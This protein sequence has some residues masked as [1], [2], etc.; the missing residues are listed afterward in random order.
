LD[1]PELTLANWNLT[2]QL[3]QKAGKKKKS[4]EKNKRLAKSPLK[5]IKFSEKL[6]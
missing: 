2:L 4:L 3:S 1:Q 5:K 6:P